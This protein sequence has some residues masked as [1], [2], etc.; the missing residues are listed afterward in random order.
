MAVSRWTNVVCDVESDTC[1]NDPYLA[2]TD[3]MTKARNDAKAHGWARVRRPGGIDMVDVCPGCN[4]ED[5][6]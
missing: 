3:N 5:Q 2:Y 1:E 6:A 4:T